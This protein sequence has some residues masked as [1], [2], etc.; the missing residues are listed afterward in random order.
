MPN[1]SITRR[2]A[3]EPHFLIGNFPLGSPDPVAVFSGWASEFGDIFYYRAGWIHV[4]F[5]NHPNFVES[6]LVNQYQSFVKD[7]V[8][9]NARWLFGNGLLTNEGDSWLKQRRIIQPAFHRDR[10]ASYA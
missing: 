9:R 3:P 4:Y 8:V 7:R 5:L 2:P 1:R 10:I 6:V